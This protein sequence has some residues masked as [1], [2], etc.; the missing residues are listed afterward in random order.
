[1]PIAVAVGALVALALGYRFYSKH[2]ALHVWQLGDDEPV[3]AEQRH[4]GVDFVKTERHVL[5]GHHFSSIAGAAPILGPAI[6][7]VWGWVPALIWIV[8]GVIF[9]GATHDFGALVLSQR[10]E[11][12]S[13]GDLS[14]RFIGRRSRLL[15]DA[16]AGGG[17]AERAARADIR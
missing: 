5:W 8:V 3:P 10:H 12:R 6:A 11:G 7:I 13:I 14:E 15:H 9:M 17:K 1:M 4:D 2:L 16:S